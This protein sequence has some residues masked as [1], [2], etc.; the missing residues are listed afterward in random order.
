MSV[1]VYPVIHIESA[2][3]AVDQAGLVF[4]IGV[5]G[6][7]LIDHS[8]LADDLL[9]PVFQKVKGEFPDKFVGV[10]YL[11]FTSFEAMSHLKEAK[12]RDQITSLP[13]G[14]WVDNAIADRR[15]TVELRRWS[16][17]LKK[18]EYLGGVAF[19]YTYA[20]TENPEFAA[21]QAIA[22]SPFVDV[23]TTTGPGTGEPPQPNKIRAMKEAIGKKPL[24]IASGI[25]A[26][27]LVDYLGFVDK[28]LVSSSLETFKYSGRFV[29]DRVRE[30]VDV[31]NK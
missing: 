23:V 29:E 3:Q 27:N 16:R 1:E 19:K 5:N 25:D 17:N 12:N 15:Q 30:L 21:F 8:G 9:T 28:L 2:E 11:E 31:A 20:Y 7:F 6:V 26:S 18:I 22:L 14:L 24:A 13:D 10:N 4:D